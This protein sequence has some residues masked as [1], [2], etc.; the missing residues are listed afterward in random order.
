MEWLEHAI[1][2]HGGLENVPFNVGTK[3]DPIL[4]TGD[5]V[6]SEWEKKL[7][8]GEDVDFLASLRGE[9]RERVEKFMRRNVSAPPP[10]APSTGAEDEGD[11][12]D[13]Y[14]RGDP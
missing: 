8:A 4:Q 11:F 14:E 6:A 3:E 9:D 5:A 7:A 13:D 10:S 12:A 1:E 2:E